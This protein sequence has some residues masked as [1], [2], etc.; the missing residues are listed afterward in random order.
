[1]RPK[2]SG[3]EILVALPE[4]PRVARGRGLST[5]SSFRFAVGSYPATPG[6]RIASAFAIKC[7]LLFAVYIGIKSLASEAD[8]PW[9][10]SS[11][12]PEISRSSENAAPTT[13][14][15]APL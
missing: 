12:T 7:L 6:T 13:A 14:T 3:P 1:M 9:R 8:A 2:S 11:S 15:V 4:A 10:R 5:V